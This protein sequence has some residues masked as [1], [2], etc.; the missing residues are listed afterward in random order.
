MSSQALVLLPR[1]PVFSGGFGAAQLSVPVRV[2]P[3]LIPGGM[4][5]FGVDDVEKVG[6]NY[7]FLQFIE[8]RAGGAALHFAGVYGIDQ[9][10]S[11]E[12]IELV[13]AI[14][15]HHYRFDFKKV[16]AIAENVGIDFAA[17][18][19]GSDQA[20][21]RVIGVF[22][23]FD[24]VGDFGNIAE[25]DAGKLAGEDVIETLVNRKTEKTVRV[26][27]RSAGNLHN[28]VKIIDRI[29]GQRETGHLEVG[30]NLFDHPTCLESRI[31]TQHAF[32]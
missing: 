20:H 13:L 31:D 5:E 11:Y 26:V 18:R 8:F 21:E 6:E 10:K 22:A 30:I 7:I 29:I 2:D 15:L 3:R 23:V 24:A 27:R 19:F 1:H 14:R 28:I 16:D 32:Q 17:E 9:L 25:I 4:K 12:K